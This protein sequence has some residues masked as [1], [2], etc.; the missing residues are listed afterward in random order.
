[1]T[2]TKLP[3]LR[4]LLRLGD[5]GKAWVVV[6]GNDEHPLTFFETG[7]T[8][9]VTLRRINGPQRRIR[10]R[11]DSID[12]PFDGDPKSAERAD[13]QNPPEMQ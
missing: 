11:L 4:G 7:R 6:P 9:S 3:L 1:V 12:S 13:E 5:P 10:Q 8:G 2:Q